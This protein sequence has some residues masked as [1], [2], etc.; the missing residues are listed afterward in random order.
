MGLGGDGR[1]VGVDVASVEIV[2]VTRRRRARNAA[3]RRRPE[4]CPSG[5]RDHFRLASR[6][7]ASHHPRAQGPHRARTE[8][9]PR[10]KMNLPRHPTHQPYRPSTPPPLPYGAAGRAH[11]TTTRCPPAAALRRV[12]REGSGVPS[13]RAFN[14]SDL[15]ALRRHRREGIDEIGRCQDSCRIDAISGRAAPSL[16]GQRWDR[17]AV[18][19]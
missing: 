13:T 17:P 11:P 3:C 19:S 7:L 12:R 5:V 15:L 16:S 6:C 10:Q 8:T 2:S 18:G 14:F 9:H 4:A 1:G